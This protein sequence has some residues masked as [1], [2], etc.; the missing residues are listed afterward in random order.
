MYRAIVR[1][2]AD[3]IAAAADYMMASSEEVTNDPFIWSDLIA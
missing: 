3:P 1:I 2:I